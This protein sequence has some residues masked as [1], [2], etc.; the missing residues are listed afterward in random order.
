MKINCLVKVKVNINLGDDP[1]AACWDWPGCVRGPCEAGC[2]EGPREEGDRRK[3]VRRG[4]RVDHEGQEPPAEAAGG[5]TGAAQAKVP[6]A[7]PL[8]GEQGRPWA[9]RGD[10]TS[11]EHLQPMRSRVS[12]LCKNKTLRDL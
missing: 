9:G 10:A 3:A 12:T 11:S 8:R 6:E 1:A 7:V 5:A 4:S 2:L